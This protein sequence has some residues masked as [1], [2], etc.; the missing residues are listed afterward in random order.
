M[1]HLKPWQALLL[2]TVLY[3][4]GTCDKYGCLFERKLCTRDQFC[5]DD[6]LFGQCRTSK[7]DQV[8]YQV[9]VP[10][11]KRMQEVLKQLMLEGLSWQDDI[12]QYILSKELKRVPHTTLPS[13]PNTSSLSQSKQPSSHHQSSKS[14]SASPSGKYVDYMIVEPPQSPLRIQT[15]SMDPYA[16][17]QHRYQDEVE[18]SLMG[19][20][21][22]YAR[23][24]LRSQTN[25][26]ERDRDRQLLL[27]ALSLYLASAQPSYRHRGAPSV[28]PAGID[29]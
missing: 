6:G 10:V 3:Q 26:R 12:T 29:K 13:K 25:Q 22:A 14:A 28:V 7:Q 1:Q 4:P 27:E 19:S 20:A 21:G 15:A 8:Q 2:L 23:P 16:Y 18:R 5:S 11:L 17:L 9:S 24:S